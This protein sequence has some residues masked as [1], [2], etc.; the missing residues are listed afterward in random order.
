MHSVFF[1]QS[2]EARRVFTYIAGFAIFRKGIMNIQDFKRELDGRI[3]AYDLLTHPFYRVWTHGELTRED[4]Q[5]YAQQ[6]YFQIA[7][8]PSYLNTLEQRLLTDTLNSVDGRELA[9]TVAQNRAE[10]EGEASPD[11]Y[12][13]EH[14][15]HAELWLDFVEGMGADR[16]SAGNV[17]PL[18]EIHALVDT[19]QKIAQEGSVA[20]ALAA[21]Y[22]YESQ[23]PRIAV[24]KER[25]LLELYGADQST[26]TYF[27]VHKTADVHHAR[28]W[29]EQLE[30]QVQVSPGHTE[31]ALQAAE[32]VAQALWRALDGIERD[33]LARAA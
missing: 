24:E 7:A 19:F 4:L 29:S 20:E 15:S 14:R 17:E 31:E 16:A 26:C 9:Q 22:A 6:Y 3:A 1:P 30:K 21:F 23:V 2:F 18:P 33:R 13:S 5:R 12:A 28:V 10:E 27:T 11:D 25:G 32:Q 8:F